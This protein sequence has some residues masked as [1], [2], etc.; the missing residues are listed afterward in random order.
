MKT[1]IMLKGP[2]CLTLI[3]NYEYS[4]GVAEEDIQII[5]KI[6]LAFEMFNS[7]KNQVHLNKNE[8]KQDIHLANTNTEKILLSAGN[9]GR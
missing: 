5:D 9:S 2:R 8:G 1:A 4:Q 6:F 7:I 3:S